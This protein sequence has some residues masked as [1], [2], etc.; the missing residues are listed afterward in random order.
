MLIYIHAYI[1]HNLHIYV[2]TLMIIMLTWINYWHG[3]NIV[4]SMCIHICKT[5]LPVYLQVSVWQQ[6]SWMAEGYWL[7]G[8]GPVSL[9]TYIYTYKYIYIHIYIY[10]YKYI[11]TCTYHTSFTY[12]CTY[13]NIYIYI[14]TP[15]V[16]ERSLCSPTPAA[17]LTRG[18]MGKMNRNS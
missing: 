8:E 3:F 2:Y 13:L 1:I 11:H 4:L 6:Q 9:Y 18:R 16:G 12:I 14:S 5:Y 17:M 15:A 10:T 7:E